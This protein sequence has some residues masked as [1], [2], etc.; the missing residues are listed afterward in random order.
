MLKNV[1]LDGVVENL[2]KLDGALPTFSDI[3]CILDNVLKCANSA[4]CLGNLQTNCSNI[5]DQLLSFSG[6]GCNCTQLLSPFI[7]SIIT[8]TICND[9]EKLQTALFCYVDTFSQTIL[10]N[11]NLLTDCESFKKNLFEKIESNGPN[12][13]EYCKPLDA[14]LRKQYSETMSHIGCQCNNLVDSL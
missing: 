11:V 6:S 14:T 3:T 8:T 5:K 13:S 10:A 12:E 2:G 9:I 4:T 1:K 7:N